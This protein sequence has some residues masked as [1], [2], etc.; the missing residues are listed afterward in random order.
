M[1]CIDKINTKDFKLGLRVSEMV[2]HFCKISGT[3][4]KKAFEYLSM[5]NINDLNTYQVSHEDILKIYFVVK[6]SADVDYIVIND[7]FKKEYLQFEEDL[8]KLLTFMVD[9]GKKII[10]L[11]DEMYYPKVALNGKIKI[12]YKIFPLD[13]KKIT[14]R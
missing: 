8:L 14:L 12:D 10:Y 2:K 1:S 3:S 5:L 13:F 6:A 9:E 7:F 11:S 4:Q